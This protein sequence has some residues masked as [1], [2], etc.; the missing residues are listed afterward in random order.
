M[1]A[2]IAREVGK[3]GSA[4][5]GFRTGAERGKLENSIGVTSF[6]SIL[7]TGLL[8]WSPFQWL[9]DWW[10]DH[11]LTLQFFYGMG[12]LALLLIVFQTALLLFGSDDALDVSEGEVGILSLR[13]ISA[14]VLGFG[15]IGAISL[16]NGFSLMISVIFGSLTGG[17]LMG[18]VTL[19][20]YALHRMKASGTLKYE[21]AVGSVGTVYLPIPAR[22]QG[23]GKVE[24]YIQ[25]RMVIV[26]AYT[27]H[28]ERIGNQER[29]R[30]I[31]MVDSRTVMVEPLSFSTVESAK[32]SNQGSEE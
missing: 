17:A 23:A 16:E 1:P 12:I 19:V 32:D 14:F 8:F 2:V 29:V 27:R 3:R 28:A 30:I 6:F 26:P 31:E 5:S 4:F 20:M 22:Q 10:A 24:A 25:G 13:A 7:V 21:N 18:T 15:W 11:S 9:S